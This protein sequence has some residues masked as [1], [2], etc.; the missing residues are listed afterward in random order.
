MV[1]NGINMGAT[2]LKTV[3]MRRSTWFV[4]ITIGGRQRISSQIL[5]NAVLRTRKRPY[6][7]IAQRQL[8]PAKRSGAT[9]AM[10]MLGATTIALAQA[11]LDV[12]LRR[13]VSARQ[14]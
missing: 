1:P 9:S 11:I 3:V 12:W 14:N 5:T 6:P 10:I 4:K 2:A 8:A 7:G 13:R